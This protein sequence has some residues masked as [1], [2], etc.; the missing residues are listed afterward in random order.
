MATPIAHH[1]RL[2]LYYIYI[3]KYIVVSH[4]EQ[5][6]ALFGHVCAEHARTATRYKIYYTSLEPQKRNQSARD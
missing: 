2:C 1:I 3:L 5:T 4:I 6:C